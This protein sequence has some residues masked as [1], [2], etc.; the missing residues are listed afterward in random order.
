MITKSHLIGLSACVGAVCLLVLLSL[1]VGAGVYGFSDAFGYLTGSPLLSADAQLAMVMDTLRIPRTLCAV[2]VG[3]SMALA[4]SLLQSATRNPLAEP[5]LLGVNAGAVLGL[6]IGLSYFEVESTQG[7]LVWSGLG[8]L[9]GN[10]VVLLIGHLVGKSHPLKLILVGVALTATFGGL[11]NYI[12]LSNQVVLD[13]FRFWNLGS[14]AAADMDAMLMILPFLGTA[15]VLTFALTRQLTLMQLGEHQAKSLGIN[16]DVVR[17]G[18][19]TASTLFTACAIS[20]A[21]PIG[22]VGFLAAYCAR[23]AEPVVLSLQVVFSALFGVIFLFIA[24]ILAR[25]LIQPF[26]MPNGVI[27]ALIGAPVLI[28]VVHRGGFRSLLAVK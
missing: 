1:S 15:V 11:S 18:V 6:V 3:V 21:G 2:I 19:M 24:D 7:Y 22:F 10:T 25:W 9:M 26:E 17:V 5:G 28:A 4:A 13:Q 8:A 16:T 27:L 14:L 23:M 20:V 12:L